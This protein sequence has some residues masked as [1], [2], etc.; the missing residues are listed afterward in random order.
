MLKNGV[1]NFGMLD[2]SRINVKKLGIF[3]SLP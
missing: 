2:V 1:E 3:S